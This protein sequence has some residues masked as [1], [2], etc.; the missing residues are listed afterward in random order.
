MWEVSAACVPDSLLMSIKLQAEVS[1]VLVL[2][3][4]FV[5]PAEQSVVPT[6][7]E[8]WHCTQ[9]DVNLIVDASCTFGVCLIGQLMNISGL[10][11]IG[12]LYIYGNWLAS[13]G[14]CIS[15]RPYVIGPLVLWV[16][17][18]FLCHWSANVGIFFHIYVIR[19]DQWY[20]CVL[21][22]CV[23]QESLAWS[24]F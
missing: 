22:I 15:V 5:Y 9:A 8:A 18:A 16:Y 4:W 24:H 17:F 2:P 13:C 14:L 1:A 12:Q 20:G 19:N 10:C 11:M 3:S 6:N 23:C 7:H 21:H